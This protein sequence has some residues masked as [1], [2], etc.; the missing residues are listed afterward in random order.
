MARHCA[1]EDGH[2][3]KG[4]EV[5]PRF[6]VRRPHEDPSL[7]PQRIGIQAADREYDNVKEDGSGDDVAREEELGRNPGLAAK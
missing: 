6:P 3:V 2:T 5:P 1:L 4:V 7:I